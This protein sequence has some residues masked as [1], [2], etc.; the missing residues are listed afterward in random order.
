MVMN[1]VKEHIW[2]P[3]S[4]GYRTVIDSKDAYLISHR[5][6]A[7]DRG[8]IIYAGRWVKT[9]GKRRALLMHRVILG[10]KSSQLIDHADHDGLNNRRT[11]LRIAT[12]SQNAMNMI[13]TTGIYSQFKGVTWCRRTDKWMSQITMDNRNIFL[14]RFNTEL[15]AAIAYN[16]A[17]LRLFGRFAR[18]NEV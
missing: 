10:A 18:I 11:N 17:A 15:G 14:G 16:T 2:I 9:K 5:W 6:V 12:R 13:K 1:A 8:G 7:I 3:L 4:K